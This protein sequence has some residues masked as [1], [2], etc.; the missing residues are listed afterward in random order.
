MLFHLLGISI[1][2]CASVGC[3]SGK[4]DDI[5]EGAPLV[6]RN[7][8]IRDII[9]GNKDDF[10]DDVC[11]QKFEFSARE[12]EKAIREALS[13]LHPAYSLRTH[14]RAF[15]LVMQLEV[16]PMTPKIRSWLKN[17]QKDDPK[18][19]TEVF[20]NL[21]TGTTPQF[22]EWFDI[23]FS[24][25]NSGADTPVI[26]VGMVN[27][28]IPALEW[29]ACDEG[30]RGLWPMFRPFI[31]ESS[32]WQTFFAN[33]E[34]PKLQ[35]EWREKLPKWLKEH[36]EARSY[37]IQQYYRERKKV[38]ENTTDAKN[39]EAVKM[40]LKE[41]ETEFKPELADRRGICAELK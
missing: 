3:H 5:D 17:H 11:W 16:S 18:Q 21:T 9:F 20:Y 38:L 24:W 15:N 14:R 12:S 6:D 30:A 13:Y 32:L 10:R 41:F 31:P 29:H 4:G 37:W 35:K 33:R 40:T 26:D 39:K 1:A 34:A 2:V 25:I 19:I 27:D 8:C 23:Y 28:G 36:P 7:L 22:P